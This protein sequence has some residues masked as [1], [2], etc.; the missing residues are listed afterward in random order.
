MTDEKF[1]F[2]QDV[3]EKKITARSSYNRKTHN[4]KSGCTL[5]HEYMSKKEL[6]S[7]N[8]EIETYRLNDPLTWQE[9]KAMP[10]DIRAIYIKAIRQRYNAPDSQIAKMMGAPQQTFSHEI[11]RLSISKGKGKQGSWDKEGFFAWR[12]GVIAPTSSTEGSEAQ[13]AEIICEK[14]AEKAIPCAGSMTFSGNADTALETVKAIL[15]GAA[16]NITV[17]WETAVNE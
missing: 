11:R 17:T 8:S 16:V 15:G 14:K 7:M 3:K 9:Y 2:I 5:P 10:D 13:Q 12:H 1:I 4:G 6:E